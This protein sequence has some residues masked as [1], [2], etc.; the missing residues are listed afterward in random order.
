M[1]VLENFGL[2]IV[3]ALGFLAEWLSGV[4]APLPWPLVMAFAALPLL[5]I[6]S[7]VIWFLRGVIWPVRC[8]YPDTTKRSGGDSACRT[9]VA[10]EWGYCRHHNKRRVDSRNHQI[11]PKLPRWQHVVNGEAVDRTDIRGTGANVSL[12]FYRGFSRSPR[13]VVSAIPKIKQEWQ[14][15]IN[16]AISKIK[17]Q[18][19][20]TP[21]LANAGYVL[22]AEEQAKYISV[23]EKAIRA[24]Q[25]L[26]TLKFVLP[27]SF[28]LTAASAFI[29]GFMTVPLEYAALFSIWIVFGIIY[30]GLIRP[31]EGKNWRIKVLIKS[32]QAVG[33]L[34]AVAIISLLLDQYVIPFI[35]SYLA[36]S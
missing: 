27:I 34:I 22:S 15:N 23:N 14:Q 11:D 31:L 1:G 7:F 16:I 30:Y 35:Q 17:R 25:A 26:S 28:I 24:E 4:T 13:Q 10:G 21:S 12:L 3:K 9:W 5:A 6:F 32:S 18:S 36:V 33:V 19:D 2:Y 20:V 29:K 8:K